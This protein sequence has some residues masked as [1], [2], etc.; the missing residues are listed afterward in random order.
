MP[1][2]RSL[3]HP[4][5]HAHGMESDDFTLDCSTCV[6]ANTTACEG[7]VVQHLLANDAGP[8]EFVPTHRRPAGGHRS[9]G[10]DHSAD[11]VELFAK[12]G[13]LDE[14]P[15]FVPYADFEAVVPERSAGRGPRTMPP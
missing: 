13:L 4:R 3:S 9:S 8:I 5:A 15:H 2:F 7:C 10:D 11:V 6:A 12:A 14:D 1:P